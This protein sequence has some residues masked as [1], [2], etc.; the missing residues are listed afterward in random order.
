M[1]TEPT[2]DAAAWDSRPAP[3]SGTPTAVGT[4]V[5]DAN[6]KHPFAS[7]RPA[8]IVLFAMARDVL[9]ASSSWRAE[10]R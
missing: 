10:K 4:K 3:G 6:V 7:P 8:A 2:R 9:G 1:S 5:R